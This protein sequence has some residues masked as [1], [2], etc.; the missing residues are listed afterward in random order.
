MKLFFSS[1]ISHKKTLLV[2]FLILASTAVLFFSIQTVQAQ[3]PLASGASFISSAIALFAKRG[4]ENATFPVVGFLMNAVLLIV[5]LVNYMVMAVLMMLLQ[6]AGQ[7]ID[8][9]LAVNN[10]A[11]SKTIQ[12][13][14]KFTRDMLNFVYILVLLAIA[15][16]TIVGLEQYGMRRLLPK[17]IISALLVNFSLVIAGSFIQ[18]ANVMCTT[19]IQGLGGNAKCGDMATFGSEGTPSSRLSLALTKSS[20]IADAITLSSS[21]L[22]GTIAFPMRTGGLQ[23]QLKFTGDGMTQ[24]NFST[25]FSGFIR[26]IFI[27]MFCVSMITLALMLGVRVGILVVLLVLAPVP[28]ALG[29]V[30]QAESYAKQWWTKFIQYTFFLPVVI[31]LLVLAIRMVDMGMGGNTGSKGIFQELIYGNDSTGGDQLGFLFNFANMFFV[32][33]FIIMSI[34]VARAAGILGAG[35]A[36]GFAQK[37]TKGTARA[38]VAPAQL[39][40]KAALNYGRNKTGISATGLYSG[41]KE[42]WASRR[43]GQ[44]AS[45]KTGRSAQFGAGIFGSKSASD[46]VYN[47]AV[48]ENQKDMKGMDD[49]TLR[50]KMHA[51]GAEGAAAAMQL[52]ENESLGKVKEDASKKIKG[53]FSKEILDRIPKS[54]AARQ[55]YEKAW[56]KSSPEAAI[57]AMNPNDKDPEIQ[58]KVVEAYKKMKP[59]DFAKTDAG[60]FKKAMGYA[61]SNDILSQAQVMAAASSSDKELAKAVSAKI[62]EM[63]LDTSFN[64]KRDATVAYA[65]K[66]KM[67]K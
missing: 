66:I 18:V 16:S 51:G 19:A 10:L 3:A 36:I 62:A 26:I 43:A 32:S 45:A 1:L 30:P 57:R 40:G 22:I 53:D 58:N 14:W 44:L 7:F 59:E 11:G 49:D 4:L 15:F 39:V 28:F 63:E 13:F 64:P 41:V 37:V 38:A 56:T 21:K 33:L 50:A 25:I 48:A 27:G 20:F 34:V 54:S 55:K 67:H 60:E 12:E 47:K 65:R 42:G 31:F 23:G 24:A 61:G 9:F 8:L 29:I 6:V 35:A 2:L 52:M 5:D 17:L 46:A